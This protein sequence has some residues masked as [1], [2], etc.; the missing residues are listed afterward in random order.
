MANV[1]FDYTNLTEVEGGIGEG[2][3]REIS[4]ASKGP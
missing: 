4:P 2:E 1:A 3:L